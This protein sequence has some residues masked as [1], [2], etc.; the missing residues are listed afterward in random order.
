MSPLPLITRGEFEMLLAQ[1]RQLIELTNDLEYQMH[2]LGE[3][4]ADDERVSGC[5][6]VGGSLIGLL[7]DC[8]FRH[9]Q[10]VLPILESSLPRDSL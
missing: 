5:Q 8:L 2:R 3:L 9:D 1:H 4:S 10:R 6:R 7:R